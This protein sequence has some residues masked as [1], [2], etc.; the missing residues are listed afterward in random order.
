LHLNIGRS[1]AR[2]PFGKKAKRSVID[3]IAG[4]NIVGRKMKLGVIS[5]A[6]VLLCAGPALGQGNDDDDEPANPSAAPPT[7]SRASPLREARRV[8]GRRC[9]AALGAQAP[10]LRGNDRRNAVLTCLAKE[11][12]D[13]AARAQEQRVEK[14]NR[15]QFMDT[16]L[17]TGK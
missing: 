10:A 4:Q 14:A 16:C 15:T 9:A 2:T 13:C 3:R 1:G 8:A 5:L 6:L 12:Y 7:S 11:V 17:R